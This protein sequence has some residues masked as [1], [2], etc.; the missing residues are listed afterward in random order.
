[1]YVHPEARLNGF[2]LV[3][4]PKPAELMRLVGPANPSSHDGSNGKEWIEPE[5]QNGLDN[6]D[7][8]QRAG[9]ELNAAALQYAAAQAKQEQ[10]NTE[11]VQQPAS[12]ADVPSVVE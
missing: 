2:K 3:K 7:Q 1:M 4:I 8:I 6:L 12:P 10:K 5:L 11:D 9:D